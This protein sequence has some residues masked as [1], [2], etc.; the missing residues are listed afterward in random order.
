MFI[1]VSKTNSRTCIVERDRYVANVRQS[2]PNQ[3]SSFKE[4]VWIFAGSLNV[5]HKISVST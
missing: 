3:V 2:N 4:A 1:I 5:T